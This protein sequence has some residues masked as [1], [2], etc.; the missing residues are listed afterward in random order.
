M[1]KSSN[2]QQDSIK[3]NY[4]TINRSNFIQNTIPLRLHDYLEID[5]NQPIEDLKTPFTKSYKVK[6]CSNYSSNEIDNSKFAI[7]HYCPS[8]CRLDDIEKL[9]NNPIT[10]LLP[11]ISSN[12]TEID[13]FERIVLV[14]NFSKRKII[15][16]FSIHRIKQILSIVSKLHHLNIMHGNINNSTVYYN[17]DKDIIEIDNYFHAP[18]GSIQSEI[19]EYGLRG[20]SHPCGK[21]S[22]EYIADY[23]A[24]GV[25]I[26]NSFKR[27]ELFNF[28]L[29]DI[30]IAT[31]RKESFNYLKKL[32]RI[33]D[34]DLPDEIS[35]IC[36]VL[37]NGD[38]N[39]CININKNIINKNDNTC[40]I[41][42][43]NAK[44]HS[45]DI[46]KDINN[47]KNNKKYNSLYEMS[48]DIIF[49]C[50]D[51][52]FKIKISNAFNDEKVKKDED[53]IY[54]SIMIEIL[55]IRNE[56]YYYDDVFNSKDE[57]TRLLSAFFISNLNKNKNDYICI[58]NTFLNIKE[59]GNMLNYG[60]YQNDKKLINLLIYIIKSGYIESICRLSH[61]KKHQSFA[62]II[63][64]ANS[65]ASKINKSFS[66]ITNIN[67]LVTKDAISISES[68]NN[69]YN[70]LSNSDINEIYE[71]NMNIWYMMYFS[72]LNQYSGPEVN[73][74]ICFSVYEAIEFFNNT[75]SSHMNDMNNVTITTDFYDFLIIS[76][77]LKDWPYLKSIETF[78]YIRNH[79]YYIL[80]GIINS[81]YIKNTKQGINIENIIK[82]IAKNLS[83]SITSS[84]LGKSNIEIASKILEK[85]YETGNINDLI[86]IFNH[87]KLNKDMQKYQK[88]AKYVKKI[89][90]IINIYDLYIKDD[91][92]ISRHSKNIAILISCAILITSTIMII[93]KI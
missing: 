86:S 51:N 35:D 19:Y 23:Y 69:N 79:K 2:Y 53:I 72:N 36:N 33:E 61:N 22:D 84:L 10:G 18:C 45:Y 8:L 28:N 4:I 66:D 37:L 34:Y 75:L 90:E 67:K 41:I 74:K 85:V 47:N 7:V 87:N 80:L 16:N 82:S 49:N 14:T 24:I 77:K 54:R 64:T 55:N 27:T 40:N 32:F 1:F 12:L 21:G 38:I 6:I 88:S 17:E 44:N 83:Y 62:V 20:C 57:I 92:I 78:R 13:G 76:M 9:K 30:A 60:I 63:N 93:T 68:D 39:D 26:L 5:L 43:N 50:D 65:I 29:H 81:F 15:D 91:D 73:N 42:K 11:I 59:I 56:I 58:G 70:I 89:E 52:Q 3:K 46:E 31:A 25:L 71:R 48:L